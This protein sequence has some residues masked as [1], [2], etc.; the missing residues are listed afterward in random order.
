[1][2]IKIVNGSTKVKIDPNRI[3]GINLVS[4]K[5][6][7]CSLEVDGRSP[8]KFLANFHKRNK[9]ILDTYNVS[10]DTISH[11]FNKILNNAKVGKNIKI[12]VRGIATK[13]SADFKNAER[14]K[15]ILSVII[16]N[17]LATYNVKK[18]DMEKMI[19]NNPKYEY[20]LL[21]DGIKYNLDNSISPIII[22]DKVIEYNDFEKKITSLKNMFSVNPSE[23]AYDEIVGKINKDVIESYGLRIEDLIN[24]NTI[25]QSDLD[26]NKV[27]I[28]LNQK[29]IDVSMI[30]SSKLSSVE[31]SINDKVNGVQGSIDK[32]IV[33]FEE[34]ITKLN[35][36]LAKSVTENSSLK[37][38]I[39]KTELL[40]KDNDKMKKHIAE[41]LVKKNGL[42][43]TIA[44]LEK[45]DKNN[46]LLGEF[47]LR[48][49]DNTYNIKQLLDTKFYEKEIHKGIVERQ[50][51][52]AREVT[53]N[54]IFDLIKKSNTSVSIDTDIAKIQS[55]IEQIE[56]IAKSINELPNVREKKFNLF[57]LS[58][59][60]KNLKDSIGKEEEEEHN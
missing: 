29:Y 5:D 28:D 36:K 37:E 31:D 46:V 49:N 45:K 3:G 52:S 39:I 35:Q 13:F 55:D 53:M 12:V 54:S 21:I 48:T 42:E 2:L 26:K 44:I 20:E 34:T 59:T 10:L 38:R 8:Q 27:D 47:L 22:D 50:M 60:I 16:S 15:N 58:K 1:M 17:W 57:G 56:E 23:I 11:E 25:L 40:E 7:F 41:L 51:L 14:D 43:D 24:K 32:M 4:K 18:E 30:I 33:S 6:N 9:E 19:V